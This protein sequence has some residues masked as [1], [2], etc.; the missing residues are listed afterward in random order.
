MNER[1]GFSKLKSQK[2]IFSIIVVLLIIVLLS[3]RITAMTQPVIVEL[4]RVKAESLRN[5]YF[6][7]GCTRGNGGNRIFRFNYSR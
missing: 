3:E 4:C 5:F 1:L 2:H 6:Q 7:Y